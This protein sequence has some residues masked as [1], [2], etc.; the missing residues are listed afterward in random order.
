MSERL[1]NR[2]H[3]RVAVDDLRLLRWASALSR[4]FAIFEQ[5]HLAGQD[6]LGLQLLDLGGL[7]GGQRG[8]GDDV[9]RPSSTQTRRAHAL[10]TGP[11]G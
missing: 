9:A 6:Q 5:Y 8:L 1:P 7:R 3:E 4:T 11:P 2:A 10:R